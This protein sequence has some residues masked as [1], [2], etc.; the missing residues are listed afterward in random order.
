[1]SPLAALLN[2]FPFLSE[3]DVRT[4]NA[5]EVGVERRR[6]N[7]VLFEEGEPSG[8]AYLVLSGTVCCYHDLPDGGRQISQILIPG[9]LC[10][11]YA[12]LG[13]AMDHSAAAVTPA[14]VAAI[15]NA[16]M[17]D[18]VAHP[19]LATAMFRVLL[20]EAA[21]LREHLVAIGRLDAR[22]RAARLICELH[23][24]HEAVGLCAGGALR[25]PLNQMRVA[26]SLGLTPVH[27]GRVLREM[28]RNKLIRI[29]RGALVVLRIDL[30]RAMAALTDEGDDAPRMR[31]P[32]LV[33]GEPILR[34]TGGLRPGRPKSLAGLDRGK[35]GDAGG[36]RAMG[37]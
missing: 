8:A 3:E 33:A 30:I 6:E 12:F 36:L 2:K 26:D 22:T 11:A 13:Q 4:A 1:M 35:Q 20:Q 37:S 7:E 23:R 10:G 14:Q 19:R 25:L 24:R 16:A 31:Y 5:L 27:V 9:D 29:E 28:H 15:P 34:A 17:R 18:L 32:A 21:Q